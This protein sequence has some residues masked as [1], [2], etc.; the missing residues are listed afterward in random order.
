MQIIKNKTRRKQ[1][2][3]RWYDNTIQPNSSSGSGIPMPWKNRCV[4]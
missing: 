4:Y 1:T 2:N 3:K